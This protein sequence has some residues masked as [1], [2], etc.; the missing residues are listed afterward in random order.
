MNDLLRKGACYVAMA[1][2]QFVVM[3]GTGLTAVFVAKTVHNASDLYD[4]ATKKK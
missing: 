1:A 4:A 3:V 2:C